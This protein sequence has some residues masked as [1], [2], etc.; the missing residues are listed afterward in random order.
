MRTLKKLG[1][2]FITAIIS[3]LFFSCTGSHSGNL[4]ENHSDQDNGKQ[5]KG[6]PPVLDTVDYNKKMKVFESNS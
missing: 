6:P 4:K 5:L 1:S 2:F 3:A